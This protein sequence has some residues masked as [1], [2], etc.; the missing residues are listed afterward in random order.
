MVFKLKSVLIMSCLL[1]GKTTGFDWRAQP[2][3]VWKV[4]LLRTL[5]V[6]WFL[7]VQNCESSLEKNELSNQSNLFL[8]NALGENLWKRREHVLEERK[9]KGIG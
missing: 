1:L 2:D 5:A 9:Q 7:C 6:L 3:D 8:S 4:W